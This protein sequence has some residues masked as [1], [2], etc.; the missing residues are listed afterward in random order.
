MEQNNLI[1]LQN[2]LQAIHPEQLFKL[3]SNFDTSNLVT[4]P[5]EIVVTFGISSHIEINKGFRS[6]D[7]TDEEYDS[8]TMKLIRNAHLVIGTIPFDPRE[9]FALTIPKAAFIFQNGGS[10]TI[11]SDSPNDTGTTLDI[12]AEIL[13]DSS[14]LSQTDSTFPSYL[15]INFSKLELDS[16]FEE[17]VTHAIETIKHSPL[18]KV[19]LSKTAQLESENQLTNISLYEQMSR[20]YPNAYLFSVDRFVGASPELVI[21]LNT[22]TVASHPLA[23]TASYQNAANLLLSDKDQVEHEFVVKQILSNLSQLGI[24]AKK[25]ASPSI[26]RFG[27]LVHLGTE[28]TGDIA[29]DNTHSS[30][31]IAAKIAPTAAICGDPDDLALAYISRYET[32]SRGMYGGIVGY[33]KLGGDGCWL[34]NIRSIELNSTKALIR[35]GVGLIE[36]SD[37][38]QENAEANSKLNSIIAGISRMK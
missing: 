4:G 10:A 18:N 30:L 8:F 20:Y 3:C 26:T 27:P 32:K 7:P 28:I 9:T 22:N 23:G 6:L 11:S 37:P 21:Q 25:Q 33:Q 13:N 38:I 15:N 1:H 36:Q 35:A 19:V 34:L 16:S 17:R 5:D 29:N 12:I 2:K 14:T 31:E 24:N